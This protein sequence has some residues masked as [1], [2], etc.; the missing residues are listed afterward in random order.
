MRDELLTD[1]NLAVVV[2]LV[3]FAESRG[4]TILKL[5]FLWLLRQ[6]TVTSVSLE[7]CLPSRRRA[8]PQPPDGD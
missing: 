6:P 4:H 3:E 1:Q 7:R 8:T 5:A 2:E